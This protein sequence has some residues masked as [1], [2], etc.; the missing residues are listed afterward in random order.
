MLTPGDIVKFTSNL[1]RDWGLGLVLHHAIIRDREGRIHVGFF[2]VLT[3]A[4]VKRVSCN[5]MEK[6]D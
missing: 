5:F 6:L 3:A 2:D 4:G 1:Y